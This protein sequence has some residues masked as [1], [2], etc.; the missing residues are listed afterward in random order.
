MKSAKVAS[1]AV[2]ALAGIVV[3]PA[4][5]ARAD[6]P[7]PVPEMFTTNSVFTVPAGVTQVTVTVAAAGG[8]GGGDSTAPGYQ[9]W[10]GGGGGEGGLVTCQL[11]VTPGATYNVVVGGAGGSGG[12]QG[13]PDTDPTAGYGDDGGQA[14]A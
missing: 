8:G 10:G 4:A 11:T 9:A 12:S 14:G 5:A 13:A 7:A 3:L 1:I 2:A 6:T